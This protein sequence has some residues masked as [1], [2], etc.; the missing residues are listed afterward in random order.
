MTITT[1]L[2]ILVAAVIAD[3]AGVPSDD[4]S[5]HAAAR[6]FTVPGC[7]VAGLFQGQAAAG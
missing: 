5:G 1:G 2:A 7:H 4:G 6:P 3:T